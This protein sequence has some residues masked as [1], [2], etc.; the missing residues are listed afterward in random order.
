MSGWLHR[1]LARLLQRK[2]APARVRLELWD[3][4]SPHQS[5]Q[6]ANRRPRRG[7]RT[8][9]PR[10]SVQPASAIWWKRYMAGTL[11]V[12]ARARAGA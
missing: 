9:A 11:K 6:P 3:G 12:R 1:W 8:N 4:T 5:S 10:C 2:L 7:R